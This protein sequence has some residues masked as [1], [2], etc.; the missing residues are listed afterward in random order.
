[1]SAYKKAIKTMIDLLLTKTQCHGTTEAA[2]RL[3]YMYQTTVAINCWHGIDTAWKGLTGTERMLG[4]VYMVFT[5]YA[6]ALWVSATA[7][8]PFSVQARPKQAMHVSSI[9]VQRSSKLLTTAL[10]FQSSLVHDVFVQSSTLTHMSIDL[11]AESA[12][13]L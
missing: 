1:M 4:S 6:A 13:Y 2:M 8:K 7:Y 3:S 10:K 11:P 12:S 9:V 5:I